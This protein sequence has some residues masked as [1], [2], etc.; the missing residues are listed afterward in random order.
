MSQPSSDISISI[1][2]LFR[3]V[4]GGLVL[5]AVLGLVAGAVAYTLG[6][7]QDPVFRAEATLLVARTTGGFSQ[8][9]LSP[10]TAPPID[11]SAY[12]AAARSDRVLQDA[13]MRLGVEAPTDSD[14]R[15]LRGRTSSFV[16]GDGRDSSLLG[17]EARAETQDLAV[18]RANAA[19]E[20]L[21]AWDQRRATDSLTRVIT[22]LEQQIGALGEQIRVLQSS[23]DGAAATQVDGLI[24][25][26]AE[27]QQQMAYARALV[28]SA[29]GLL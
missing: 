2:D 21:V 27:Q 3:F 4:L 19:A 16:A 26:R 1:H 24:R 5:A 28:A 25:L 17:V 29:E 9:G 12:V 20:A 10:V 13:L 11:L 6:Q 23:T 15:S 7:R 18:L 22:T 14:I 8:F